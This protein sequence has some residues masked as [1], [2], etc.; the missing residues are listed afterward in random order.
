M[1]VS[2]FLGGHGDEIIVHTV[3]LFYPSIQSDL[4]VETGKGVDSRLFFIMSGRLVNVTLHNNKI[5]QMFL[6]NNNNLNTHL[7]YAMLSS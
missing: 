2:T 4:H 5:H 3:T 7:G 6:V 1:N